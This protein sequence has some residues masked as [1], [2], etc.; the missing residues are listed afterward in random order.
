LPKLIQNF[1]RKQKFVIFKKANI[2]PIG[3]KSPNLVTLTG[4]GDDDRATPQGQKIDFLREKNG[5]IPDSGKILKILA[6]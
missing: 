2:Q 4:G 6:T 5:E 3:E 1:C